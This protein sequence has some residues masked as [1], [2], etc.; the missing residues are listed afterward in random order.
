VPVPASGEG[1]R[2][3]ST[4]ARRWPS[5]SWCLQ[6]LLAVERRSV[7]IVSG[8]ESIQTLSDPVESEVSRRV[9]SAETTAAAIRTRGREARALETPAVSNVA[10]HGRTRPFHPGVASTGRTVQSA[11]HPDPRAVSTNSPGLRREFRCPIDV[12]R[13]PGCMGSRQAPT[14]A[15]TRYRRSPSSC[16][17]S[18]SSTR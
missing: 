3:R 6:R 18:A 8:W 9:S 14:A 11:R 7:G 2:R 13:R 10:S 16:R 4:T 5:A 12:T 17:R 15:S 1:S